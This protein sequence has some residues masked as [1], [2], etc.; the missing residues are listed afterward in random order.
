VPR[1]QEE[2]NRVL[3]VPRRADPAARRTEEP[4]R[5]LG[6]PMDSYGLVDV[7]RMRSLAHP[8]KRY[9]RWV[10]HRRFGPYAPEDD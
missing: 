2:R 6:I 3:G 9:K 1:D 5:V 4:Q 10:Q 7:D 8:I